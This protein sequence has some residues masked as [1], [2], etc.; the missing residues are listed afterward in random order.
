[1]TI[2]NAFSIS[3]VKA[4]IMF[5]CVFCKAVKKTENAFYIFKYIAKW[6]AYTGFV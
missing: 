3:S 1:M 2:K 4:R 6:H 5:D